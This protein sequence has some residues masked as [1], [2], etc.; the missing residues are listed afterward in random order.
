[1][2]LL[3]H[4]KRDH[5]NKAKKVCFLGSNGLKKGWKGVKGSKLLRFPNPNCASQL[6]NLT[7]SRAAT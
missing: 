2:P 3:T 5:Q 4:V 7:M 6:E 1:M